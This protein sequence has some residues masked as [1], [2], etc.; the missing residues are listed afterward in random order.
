MQTSPAAGWQEKYALSTCVLDQTDFPI[1]LEKIAASGFRWIE[2]GG[3]HTHLDCRQN[4]DVG[5]AAAAIRR[6]GLHVHSLHTPF[7]G[8]RLGHPDPT[9]L[10]EWLR[11]VGRSLEIGTELGA[12]YAIIH[13]TGEPAGLTDAMHDA[14]R[15]INIDYIHA[16]QLRARAL[17]ICLALENMLLRPH[18]KARY[19]R[20]L[21]E[22]C[23]DFPDPQIGFCLDTGHAAVAGLDQA[24]EIRAAGRRLVTTHLA[25]NDGVDDK[26]WLPDRGLVDWPSVRRA[27]VQSGYAGRYLLELKGGD[28]PDGVLAQAVAFAQ[29]DFDGQAGH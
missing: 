14:C 26:H 4:P 12:A 20:S 29:A 15:Q 27:L 23:A 6:L 2:V 3:T 21:T 9:L 7:T 19:G 5:A 8:L 13:V 25:S 10:P 17:G 28:D 18:L 24:A 22:L 1:A 11:V 16:L